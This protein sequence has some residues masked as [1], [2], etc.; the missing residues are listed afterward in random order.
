[1]SG[2]SD[3]TV[4]NTAVATGSSLSIEVS[5]ID[6]GVKVYFISYTL[7]PELDTQ[8]ITAS[9]ESAYSDETIILETNADSATWSFT[10]NTAGASLSDAEGKDTEVSATQPGSVTVQAV[11]A[12]YTTVTKS[13]TF[14]ERPAGTFYDV[15]FNSNGGS[16]SPSGL[17]VLEGATFTFPSPG[18]KA[19]YSFDGWTSTG[20]APYYAVDATSPAIT[21]DITYTAHWTEDAKYVVEYVSDGNGTGSYLEE[22]YGGSYELLSYA[23]ISGDV[24]P[25]SGYRFKDYTVGGVH[26]NPG[27]EIILSDDV[28]VTVNFEEIPQAYEIFFGSTK[29]TNPDGITT[30]E[31]FKNTYDFNNK[32][33]ITISGLAKIYGESSTMLKLGSSKATASITFAIPLSY[34]ITSVVVEIDTAGGTS[35]N[36]TSGADDAET[37]NQA[38]AAGTLTFDNY[39]ASERSN[40]VTLASTANGAFYVTSIIINYETF[41]HDVESLTTQTMLSYRYED[42]GSGGFNFSDISIRFGGLLSKTLWDELDT[43]EHLISGFGVMITTFNVVHEYENIK[44]YAAMAVSADTHPNLNSNIANYYMPKV[45]EPSMSTPPESGDNYAWNLFFRVD[46]EDRDETYIA[47]A[48]IKVGDEYVFFGQ[49]YYSVISLS[50]DYLANRGCNN[51]TADGSLKYLSEQTMMS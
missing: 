2:S 32:G 42:N 23:S 14:I 3:V 44:D 8:I 7:A 25:N 11:A 10:A 21:G 6:K 27:D 41:R 15:T 51:S 17:E 34:Y 1:M 5:N 47:A 13:L 24:T 29:D 48:Y 4:S 45:G 9:D 26:K 22:E 43:S 35:M 39:L 50:L 46:W 49:K 16:N 12:G 40:S 18:T 28:E 19:H 31:G 30:D 37:E 36:V 33:D 20:S 38:I